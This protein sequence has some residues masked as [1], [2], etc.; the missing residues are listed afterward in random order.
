MERR[1]DRWFVALTSKEAAALIDELH[2]DA[3]VVLTS[4]AR[5]VR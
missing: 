5:M 4:E 2:G 3:E 1:A